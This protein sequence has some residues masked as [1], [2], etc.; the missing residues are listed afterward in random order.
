M[1]DINSNTQHS[2]SSNR[3]QGHFTSNKTCVE[4]YEGAT[5]HTPISSN[6]PQT[7]LFLHVAVNFLKKRT[8][9]YHA[10]LCSVLAQHSTNIEVQSILSKSDTS[11][12]T[13]TVSVLEK[14]PSYGV[15]T[16]RCKER[17]APNL[18]VRFSKVSIL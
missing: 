8:K 2:G 12:G 17:Q 11:F 5:A 6:S 14:C 3:L 4:S 13:S 18:G 15:S 7:L 9:M 16:K 10:G 1:R